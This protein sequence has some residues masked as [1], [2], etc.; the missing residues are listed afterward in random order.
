[1]GIRTERGCPHPQQASITRRLSD[2]SPPSDLRTLLRVGTPA[3]RL[4]SIPA[5]H[6]TNSVSAAICSLQEGMNE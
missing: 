5:D 1:M 2:V 3:L 6:W 4:R